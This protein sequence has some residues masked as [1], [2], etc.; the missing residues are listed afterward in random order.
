MGAVISGQLLSRAGGHYRFQGM[1]G[2]AFMA[3]GLFL[4]SRMTVNTTSGM[5][6][7]SIV[8]MGLGLGITM[9]VYLIAVQNAVPHSVLGIATSTTTF[10]R[11]IGGAF[12]LAITGSVMNRTFISEFTANLPTS[13]A[14]VIPPE[15]LNAIADNPQALVNPEAQIQ[16]QSLFAGSGEQGIMLFNNLVATLR[17]ALT[18]AL[19]DVFLISFVV[20][21][22]A[23]IVSFFIK[24]I[25]LRKRD[26]LE[27]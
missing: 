5:A 6:I 7:I 8:V 13:V 26:E 25:P 12:G 17:Q 16:L 20:V 14:Q 3:I 23:L 4:M 22:V 18:T 15:Q 21:L 2:I 11:S 19:S 1:A 27:P 24:E 9:P 10:F